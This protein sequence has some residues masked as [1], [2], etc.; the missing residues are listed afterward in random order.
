MGRLS[1]YSSCRISATTTGG[2]QASPDLSWIALRDIPTLLCHA[3]REMFS[4]GNLFWTYPVSGGALIY[5]AS[6]LDF[7]PKAL[8]GLIGFMD[9]FFFK[10]LFN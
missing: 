2:S 7:I 9:N 6:P 8:F 4:V 5:L 3:F 10:P 1:Q